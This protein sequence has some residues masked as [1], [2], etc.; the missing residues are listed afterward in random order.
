MPIEFHKNSRGII[1]PQTEGFRATNIHFTNFDEG[2]TLFKSGSKNDNPLQGNPGGHTSNFSKISFSNT[3]QTS[4]LVYWEK[5]FRD[6]Y[7]D[8]DG[9]LTGKSSFPVY[10]T[11]L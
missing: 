1:T 5:Y 2:M 11:R 10:I 8:E 7:V 3:I 6:I 4:K 9:S